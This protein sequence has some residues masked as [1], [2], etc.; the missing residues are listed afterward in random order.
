MFGCKAIA[1]KFT[2]HAVKK[3]ETLE[4]ISNTYGVSQDDILRYNKEIKKGDS[5]LIRKSGIKFEYEV[6]EVLSKRIGPKLVPEYIKE[7]T[8]IEEK[9]KLKLQ[10]LAQKTYRDKGAGRPTKKDRRDLEDFL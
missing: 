2:T 5:I 4:L 8:S 7:T 1:Q 10:Q 3:G 6:L 9:E